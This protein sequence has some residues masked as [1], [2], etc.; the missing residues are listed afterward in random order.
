MIAYPII[1]SVGRGTRH[2]A[3]LSLVFVYFCHVECI[4]WLLKHRV[5]VIMSLCLIFLLNITTAFCCCHNEDK[6]TQ[7][8]SLDFCFG[9]D[10]QSSCTVLNHGSE[11]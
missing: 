6:G 9:Q 11:Y 1:G 3:S 10:G 2:N 7:N 5:I 8:Y 4:G